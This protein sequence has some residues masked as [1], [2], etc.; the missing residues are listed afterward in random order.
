[1]QRILTEAAQIIVVAMLIGAPIGLWYTGA[2]KPVSQWG[3]K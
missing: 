2:I 1:M 3:V